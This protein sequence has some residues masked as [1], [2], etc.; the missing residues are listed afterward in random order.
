MRFRFHL[1]NSHI[2]VCLITFWG[3][4]ELTQLLFPL[5]SDD[6]AWIWFSFDYAKRICVLVFIFCIVDCRRIILPSLA[7]PWARYEG[8]SFGVIRIAAIVVGLCAAQVIIEWGR[9]SSYSMLPEFR[10]NYP[11]ASVSSIAAFVDLTIGLMLVSLSEE[12]VFRGIVYASLK[13]RK[14]S[15]AGIIFVSAI[16]FALIHISSGIPNTLA[17]AATGAVFMC[18]YIKTKSLWPVM[19]AHYLINL[20]HFT[21]LWQAS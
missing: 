17:A 4:L 1:R 9:I 2:E 8:V 16:L 3:A 7:R 5:S 12:T 18:A 14:F 11:P 20:W 15:N 6:P 21:D 19:I 13:R 10:T